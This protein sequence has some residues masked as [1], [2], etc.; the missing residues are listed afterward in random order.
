MNKVNYPFWVVVNK[1]ISDHVKSWRFIILMGIILLTCMGS[2]YTS[3][4]NIGAAIKP[5]DPDGSFLFLE[6]VHS[7]GWHIAFFCAVYQLSGAVVGDC[8]GI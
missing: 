1:E 4:T 2:L 8:A 5:N 7:L 6:A 3:L